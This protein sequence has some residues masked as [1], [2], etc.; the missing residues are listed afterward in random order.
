VA[1]R[2]LDKETRV[3]D[4]KQ[5]Q[6][7]LEPGGIASRLRQLQGKT[8]GVTFA[9]RAGMRTSKISKLRRGQQLP[10]EE[11]IRAWVA[12]AGADTA[13][14]DELIN[15]LGDADQYHS[16]Y[17]Q[18]LKNGQRELQAEY[19]ELVEQSDVVRMLERSFIPRLLQTFD[20]ARAIMVGSKNLHK[21]GDDVDAATSV[22][23][24]CQTCLTDG[25]HRFEFV[26]D[27]A[28]LTRNVATPEIMHAQMQRLL[29]A[30][31]LPDV[32]IGLLPVRGDFHDAVR[33]SF[34]L[35][36]QVG[37]VENYYASDPLDDDRLAKYE[38]VMRDIWQD[39]VEGER[40]RSLIV[41][42]MEYYTS[43]MKSAGEA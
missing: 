1:V 7:L 30:L 5:Q 4:P 13:V 20:Y 34:E 28:V 12:A 31:Y 19:N 23:L 27:E 40:A 26:I 25:E 2:R 35:Y 10:S 16:S 42:A 8:P 3:Q 39:A 33:N 6:W 29:D 38:E 41:A 14:A 18:R 43:R 24:E 11:D 32:R 21:A 15:K 37:M 17:A 9:E 22:R 36:G